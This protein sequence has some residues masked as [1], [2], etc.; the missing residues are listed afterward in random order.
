MKMA[1]F[2]HERFACTK[3]NN[4]ANYLQGKPEPN[5]KHLVQ[6]IDELQRLA[7]LAW[8]QRS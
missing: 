5:L 4:R 1:L 8:T 6:A 7:A 2:E 3:K